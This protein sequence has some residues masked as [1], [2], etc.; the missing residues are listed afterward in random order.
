RSLHATHRTE[1][2]RGARALITAETI[3]EVLV[4][5]ALSV[6]RALR[7]AQAAGVAIAALVASGALAPPLGAVHAAVLGPCA[8]LLAF[9]AKRKITSRAEAPL[10]VDLAVALYASSLACA[11]VFAYE[12]RLD[13]PLAAAFYL[14]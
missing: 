6:R 9:A 8:L 14:L 3:M 10:D 2:G 4:R 5:A 1:V 13:G 7:A 11:L 12:P